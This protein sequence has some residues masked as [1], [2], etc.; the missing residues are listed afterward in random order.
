MFIIDR[1]LL[2]QFLSVLAIFFVS[3]FGL[4]VVADAVN[5]LEEFVIYAES[6][7]GLL[8]VLCQYYGYRAFVFF[9]QMGPLLILS[10]AMFTIAAFRRH[11]EMTALMAAGIP[12]GRIV[13]TIIIT[14]I[15][16]AL[17]ATIN[18]EFLIPSVKEHLDYNAQDLVSGHIRPLRPRYDN[19]TNILLSGKGVQPRSRRIVRPNF[20]MPRGL[21]QYGRQLIAKE[22]AYLTPKGERPGGYLFRDVV[23]PDR[24]D[25]RPSL[26]L[27]NTPILLTSLDTP[28]LATDQCFV[29]SGVDFQQ[30]GAADKWRRLSSSLE[31]YRGI[32]NPSLD[33]G[34]NVQV[35][36]HSRF[37]QP[38][39]DMTL[40]MLGLPLVLSRQSRNLFVSI[41]SC[42][43]LVLVFMLVVLGCHYLGAQSTIIPGLAAWLPLIIFAPV[44]VGLAEPLI[45]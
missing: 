13:R 43:L 6:G 33:H 29:A 34:A 12:S 27:G 32:H 39:L 7:G 4:F 1:Y 14:A 21:D 38:L 24:L 37:V 11:N 41:G 22:A 30:L 2:H 45:E 35:E 44:A 18:R 40:L 5:N 25:Q 42:V 9:D 31:L 23:R 10:A 3:L 20:F 28:W 26:S 17:L 19:E 8:R 16:F 15:T 36:L